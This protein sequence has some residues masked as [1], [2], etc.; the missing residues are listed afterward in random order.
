M[1]NNQYKLSRTLMEQLIYPIIL[2]K[3][4][5]SI[6]IQF[7]AKHTIH[8]PEDFLKNS[9]ITIKPDFHE[10]ND[11]FINI[12]ISNSAFTYLTHRGTT[13][14]NTALTYPNFSRNIR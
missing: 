8:F 5:I 7:V 1:G 9:R 12:S 14:R 10:I 6:P 4:A 11:T 13:D 2:A 3:Q